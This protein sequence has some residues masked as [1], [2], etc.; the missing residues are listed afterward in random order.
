MGYFGHTEMGGR[1]M[2]LARHRLTQ[3]MDANPKITQVALGKA[4]GHHQVWI[5]RFRSGAQDADIDE[6]EAMAKMYGHTLAELFDMRPDPNEQRLVEAFR[7][8]PSSKRELGISALE[9][10][11]PDPPRKRRS[12][13]TR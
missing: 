8:L 7:A 5:S 4:V 12:V 1:L 13:G 10:M 6:L 2:E 9:A 11:L 3:W